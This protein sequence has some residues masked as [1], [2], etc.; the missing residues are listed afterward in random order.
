MFKAFGS[1][2]RKEDY[3]TIRKMAKVVTHENVE[4]VDICSYEVTTRIDDIIMC[5]GTRAWT[6]LQSSHMKLVVQFP[7]VTLLSSDYGD[8]VEREKAYN[9]LLD[10][11]AKVEALEHGASAKH[12]EITAAD[13]AAVTCTD[14]SALEA[15][16]RRR[17]IDSWLCTASDGRLIRITLESEPSSTDVSLTFRE[18]YALKAA[19]EA[20]HL[21]KV[22]FVSNTSD[23]GKDTSS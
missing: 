6:I 1:N 20:L 8:P 4:I 23:V 19:M 15:D 11:R 22:E 2:I 5:F 21:E 17:G 14:L 3:E 12:V 9:T 13:L 16:L 7:D 18:L 10:M